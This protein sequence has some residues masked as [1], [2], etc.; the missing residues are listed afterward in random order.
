MND[1]LLELMVEEIP[2]WMQISAIS[3]FEKLMTKEFEKFRIM[4]DSVRSY[5]SPRRI[6]FAARL[7]ARSEEFIEEKRGPQVTSSLEVIEK[8]LR[9][10][11]A[12]IGDCYEKELDKKI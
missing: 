7:N 9:A 11:N 2:S 10:H 3:E 12:V 6:V 8:F 4:Y 1:F 5:I